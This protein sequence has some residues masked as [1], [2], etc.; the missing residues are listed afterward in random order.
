MGPI[1]LAFACMVAAFAMIAILGRL[2]FEYQRGSLTAKTFLIGGFLFV[3]ILGLFA[4]GVQTI[5]QGSSL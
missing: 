5:V 4:A 2:F 3:G 1:L